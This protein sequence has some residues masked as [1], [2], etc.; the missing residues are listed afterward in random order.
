MEDA[1]KKRVE[2]YRLRLKTLKSERSLFEAQW[3]AISDVIRPEAA[4]FTSNWNQ[5][6]ERKGQKLY[7]AV[8]A[9]SNQLLAA[10]F[11]SMLTNP[12]T[13]WFQLATNN[14]D[15]QDDREVNVWLRDVSDIMFQEIQRPQTGFQTALH[16]LY[17]DYGAYGN[18]ILFITNAPDR[19]TLNFTALPLQ[20]SY[21]VEGPTGQVEALYRSYQRTI[22]QVVDTFGLEACSKE[23]QDAFRESRYAEK[24]NILHVIEPRR[25]AVANTIITR[26]SQLPY[27]SLYFDMDHGHLMKESGYEEKPFMAAR[28]FKT[29][30]EVYGR[31]PGST[32]LSDLRTLQ[33][34]VKNT[35]KGAQKIV[36]P[37]ILIPDE[38]FVNGLQ[39]GPGGVSY[40][41]PDAQNL[42]KII[43]LQTG[44]NP[45]WGEKIAAEIRD[46]VRSMFFVDQL[47]LNEGPQ[48]TATEVLQR[49]EEKTRLLGPVVGR[50]QLELLSP[51]IERVFMLLLR[52]GALPEPPAQLLEAAP[53]LKVIYLSQ[54]SKAQDQTEANSIL[55]ITQLITPFASVDPTVMDAFNPSEIVRG[56]GKMYAVNPKYFRSEQEVQALQAQRN[57]QAMQQAQMEQLQ[58]GAGALNDMAGGMSKLGSMEIPGM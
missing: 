11:Y 3:D 58:A 23:V 10:G 19:V 4:S 16:E 12:S 40:Y 21:F 22:Q 14:R 13:R 52:A 50:A 44:A 9:H 5:Q 33:E 42:D 47:Q 57:Q 48:M 39:M 28:F 15:M 7:D 32:A 56:L 1:A 37:P 31:G 38:A 30:Y 29:S 26:A 20:E 55:R 34:V 49:T 35:L 2:E 27:A 25:Y 24:V 45:Q 18:G 41:R 17:L 6:G 46:R 43:P 54:F 8:G 36:D 51:A 53:Q